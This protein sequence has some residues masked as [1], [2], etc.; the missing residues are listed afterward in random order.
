MDKRNKKVTMDH[1]PIR[2]KKRSEVITMV[3]V[4][5]LCILLLCT[6]I[7]VIIATVGMF[8]SGSKREK[9]FV[10]IEDAGGHR[11]IAKSGSLLYSKNFFMM[12]NKHLASM[13]SS[14]RNRG[15]AL[16]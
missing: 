15:S 16:S 11:F 9:I 12:S 7:L 14:L 1:K 10:H 5:S 3:F 2:A 8:K 13:P 4:F 6:Y